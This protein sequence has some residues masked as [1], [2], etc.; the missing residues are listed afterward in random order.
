MPRRFEDIAVVAFDLDGTLVDTAPD[1]A[2]AAN[3]MLMILGGRSLPES[4]IPALIGDGID[5]LAAKVL[6]LSRDGV[7]PEPAELST[8][9]RL[10]RSLYGQRLF[11]RSRLFPEALETLQA[12]QSAGILACCITNKEGEFTLPLL[13]A[14]GIA[15][16]VT[17]ALCAER[18]EERKPNPALLLAAC[19]R[20][21]IAPS[22]MLY[23]GDSG[24]DIIA[25]RA[26]GCRV[27]AVDYGYHRDLPLAEARPDGIISNLTEIMSATVRRKPRAAASGVAP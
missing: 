24:S 18:A 13:E 21:H 23:V 25:A 27:V 11:R 14:A 2:D 26:A 5:Q 15:D 22:R 9:A 20:L 1:L 19:R 17:F 7:A 10:F 12:L 3:M 4:C 8:A 6:T 16:L